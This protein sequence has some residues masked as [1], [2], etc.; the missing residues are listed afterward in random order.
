[1]SGAWWLP[2]T[3]FGTRPIG[4]LKAMIADVGWSEDDL[5]RLKLL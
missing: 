4:T 5:R 3:I 2:I 1:M